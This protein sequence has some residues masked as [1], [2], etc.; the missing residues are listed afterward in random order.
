MS[1]LAEL[2]PTTLVVSLLAALTTWVTLLAWT[3][4]AEFPAGYMVPLF[5]ACLI[6]AVGGMAL[7]SA[8]L[9]A[10][11]VAAGQ[12]V[13]LLLWLHHRLAG[14]WLP[15]PTSVGVA[16]DAVRQSG[17]AAQT[18]AAPVPVSV[19]EFYPLLIMAGAATAVLVDFLAV[20]LRRAPL[21]GL[22][23][24]AAYTAPVSILDGGVSVLKFAA[25][26]LCFLFLIAAEEDSRLSHWGHHLTPRG[27]P[28]E[29]RSSVIG[30]AAVWSSA[31]KIG[32]TATALAAVV[33]LLV[34]TFD[35]TLFGGGSGT[36]TGDGQAVN[37]SN[38]MVDLK[39]DLSRG[40][41]VE[42]LRMTTSDPD[43]S[44]LRISVLNSFDGEAWRPS[45]RS[46][47][48]K[49]RADGEVPPAPGL[50]AAVR[51]RQYRARISTNDFFKSRWLPTP[52]P[53]ASVDAPGDWRYDRSTMDFISAADNQTTADLR[54]R[55]TSLEL[56]PTAQQMANALPAPA[57]VF[58]PN[59]SLPRDFPASVRTLAQQVT[60]GKS[61]KFE[62]A[63]AL[64]QWFRVG[65]GFRYSLARSSGNG[66]DDLLA[67]LKKGPDGRVGYCEQFAAAMAT[68]GRTLG[69]PLAR[70]GRVPPPAALR[71]RHLGLQHPRPARLA[72][73]V[74]RRRGLGA[75]RADP[76][77]PHRR[78]AV[79]HHRAG[80][81]GAGDEQQQ[82]PLG[83]TVGEPGG[84]VQRR[85]SRPRR[86][87]A[88]AATPG[89][90]DAGG[91][92]RGAAAGPPRWWCAPRA[93]C[94]CWSGGA[95]GRPP[96][97]RRAGSR[98]R[99]WSCAT[100]PW[101]SASPGTTT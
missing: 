9:P 35:A 73:D 72:G 14:D 52:Y 34:P 51:T 101:T 63:V 100:R 88:A 61:T 4:F 47:P 49:Q 10:L 32:L 59:T 54:Y 91:L 2:R 18:F 71:R 81:A 25:A 78:R 96:T 23:L 40:A 46:I 57:S 7:R 26:A 83:R 36:G 97:T 77:E 55:L 84:Q 86:T 85:G 30:G 68:M 66:T 64:Q 95:G 6:V 12:V 99:G 80:A 19:P 28:F 45:G 62:Q 89:T 11:L 58:G 74:L 43:P 5:G 13:L 70:G 31:R 38:P 20:G 33:P 76:A 3:K 92:D 98:P 27:G 44:Y 94:G 56:S 8:R 17:V 65:G 42:L 69:H 60:A 48:V 24:L 37:I 1:R 39:R 90:G 53:V 29:S 41:D 22:P 16:L 21:A 75:L 79:V 82:R 87:R 50:Q 15:T 67:F 93:A